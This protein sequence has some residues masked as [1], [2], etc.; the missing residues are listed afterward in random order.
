MIRAGVLIP[1]ALAV[2]AAAGGA[3]TGWFAATE[4]QE[5]QTVLPPN[6]GMGIIIVDGFGQV[7]P[8]PVPQAPIDRL[9][10]TEVP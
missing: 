5:T 6:S 7:T 4:S 3:T 8:T 10:P 9:V 1:L 2:A